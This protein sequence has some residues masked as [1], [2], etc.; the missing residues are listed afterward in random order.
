MS[1]NI[2]VD[3]FYKNTPSRFS[4]SD[5]E[6]IH[7]LLAYCKSIKGLSDI[8]IKTDR[9]VVARVDGKLFHIT[10][11]PLV[12]YEVVDILCVLYGTA[13]AE[14]EVRKKPLDNAYAFR[15]D[16]ST[17][18]RYRWNATAIEKNNSVGI[19][20]T[21]RELPPTPPKLNVEEFRDGLLEALFPEKG[22]CLVCGATGSGKSTLLA[23]L[24]R[25]IMEKPDANC[26]ILEYAAPI[27]FVY[28][29]LQETAVSCEV[30]QSQVPDHVPTFAE[31]I[32]NSLRRDPDIIIIGESRDA[33]TIK[34]MILGSQTGHLVYST[35]HSTTVQTTFLRL[36]NSLPSDEAG[37]VIGSLI[38]MIQVVLCQSLVPRLGGG[39][40]PI[41]EWLIV[42]DDMRR[43]MLAAANR[44]V[45]EL[46]TVVGDLVERHGMTR[47]RY[48]ELLVAENK[49]DPKYV[50]IERLAVSKGVKNV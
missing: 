17:T 42:N 33:E 41:R 15:L 30:D 3:F 21:L 28:D 18:L 44:N 24:V 11:R 23:G 1:E 27:E 37:T 29:E 22:L 14:I 26:H 7:G 6:A 4:A 19:S 43:I 39:R 2:P 40:I 38:D 50:E 9:P 32:R 47:L 12:Q 10:N 16:R 46:P 8:L 35:V 31:G 49:I 5:K 48:A 45:M 20:I 25:H 13:N 34:A 36:I